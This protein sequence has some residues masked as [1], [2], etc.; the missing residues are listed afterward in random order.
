MTVNSKARKRFVIYRGSYW[1]LIYGL[2]LCI[3]VYYLWLIHLNDSFWL[4]E[5]LTYWVIENDL[6]SVFERAIANHGQSPLYY[7]LLW[8]FAGCFGT[9]EWVLRLPSIILM[10]IAVV[11]LYKLGKEFLGEE[12]AIYACLIFVSLGGPIF[13]AIYARPYALPLA[14]AMGAL[15]N[16]VRWGET[17]KSSKSSAFIFFS[18]FAIYGHILMCSVVGLALLYFSLSPKK[19]SNGKLCVAVIIIILFCTPLIAQAISLLGRRSELVFQPSPDLRIFFATILDPILLLSVMLACLFVFMFKNYSFRPYLSISFERSYIVYFLILWAF[20]P[21]LLAALV[22]WTTNVTLFQSRYL[23]IAAPGNA[24]LW[25]YLMSCITPR[26]SRGAVMTLTT[27]LSLFFISTLPNLFSQDWRGASQ[28]LSFDVANNSTI[29]LAT[30]MIEGSNIE[31]FKDFK[32]TQFLRAPV[33]Y[34][35]LP[36]SAIIL[37]F[38]LASHDA[39]QYWEDTLRPQLSGDRLTLVM[40]RGGGWIDNDGVVTEYKDSIMSLLKKSEFCQ[41]EILELENLVI[42]RFKRC[43]TPNLLMNVVL[44]P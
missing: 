38:Q 1:R 18:V 6:S 4:D 19:P 14:C 16:A 26:S 9:A 31:N 29:L 27:L 13:A 39:I 43:S 32:K 41:K 28:R 5:L 12:P 25:G 7:V 37:P 36:T 11:L 3:S 44:Q 35:H 33:S 15:L 40:P 17:D 42:I 10:C 21:I 8:L 2:L 23:L 22:S 24:L 34:Y 20:L 30:G